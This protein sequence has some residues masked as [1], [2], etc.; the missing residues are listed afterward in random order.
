MNRVGLAQGTDV[1]TKRVEAFHADVTQRE[2]RAP[3][4]HGST[5][6]HVE[7]TARSR[8]VLTSLCAPS[9][10]RLREPALAMLPR[11]WRCSLSPARP[12]RA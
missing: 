10:L 5:M 12:H 3:A 1:Q 2:R 8:K 7:A 6:A 4:S 9:F 11:H